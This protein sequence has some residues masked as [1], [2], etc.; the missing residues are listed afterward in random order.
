MVATMP[1]PRRRRRRARSHRRRRNYRRNP[2]F[3]PRGTTGF[4]TDA[5][6]VVGGFTLNRVAAGYV[7]PMAAQFGLPLDQP[8]IRIL[9]KIGVAFGLGWAAKMVVSGKNA[10]LIMIGGL[11]DALNDGVKT[12][13]A[14]YVPALAGDDMSVYPMLP[15]MGVYPTL[16]GG[17]YDSPLSVSSYD[18]AL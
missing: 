10:Q 8:I 7:F 5:A 18:E 15:G 4:L 1:N 6:Y 9:G 12:F 16:S 13:I 17:G 11:V 3:I 14:P 2:N